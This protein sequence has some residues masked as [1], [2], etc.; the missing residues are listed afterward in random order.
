MEIKES[1][2]VINLSVDDISQAIEMFLND[3][4]Y[5]TQNTEFTIKSLPNKQDRFTSSFVLS[6]CVCECTKKI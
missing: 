3:K 2:V 1:N 6:G 5:A 4:G